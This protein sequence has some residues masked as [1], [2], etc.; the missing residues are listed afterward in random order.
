[1]RNIA[2]KITGYAIWGLILILSV[3]LL[4]N[5]GH[6]KD[7]QKQI[8]AEKAKIE[9]IETDNQKLIAQITET[10]SPQF[11]EKQVRDKLGLG[12]E[13]EAVVV[14]PDEDTLRKLA[15]KIPQDEDT[16]PDPTWK[17][18]LNLFTSK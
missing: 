7:V 8:E 3:T 11:I 6:T 15:P 17:K 13:G 9:K 2:T 16:L 4:K 1:M 18:W 10:Q 5:I 12:R 14:L